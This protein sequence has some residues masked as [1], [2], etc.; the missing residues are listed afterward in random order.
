MVER[1]RLPP[2]VDRET[3]SD[4]CPDQGPDRWSIEKPKRTQAADVGVTGLYDVNKRA[5]Q[6]G[7]RP[8]S[9]PD[10]NMSSSRGTAKDFEAIELASAVPESIAVRASVN[11]ERVCGEDTQVRDT[12]AA[13]C[14]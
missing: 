9:K 8:S 14:S 6:A 4:N 2:H 10:A 13:V 3:R 5:D 7:Q 12:K 11:D 1:D